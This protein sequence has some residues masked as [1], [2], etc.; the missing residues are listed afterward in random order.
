MFSREKTSRL[1]I[2]TKGEI[3]SDTR[4]NLL[5]SE[6]N[7]HDGYKGILVFSDVMDEVEMATPDFS[8]FLEMAEASVN[9]YQSK[10]N[11]E[12]SPKEEDKFKKYLPAYQP[13][14]LL[15]ASANQYLKLQ[16]Y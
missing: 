12:K 15:A 16:L 7:N 8:A 10:A 1:V 3:F 5:L 2:E 11:L 14:K 13:Q 9:R 6:L 4:K